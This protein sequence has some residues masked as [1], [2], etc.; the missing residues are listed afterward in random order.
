MQHPSEPPLP[1]PSGVTCFNC[2]AALPAGTTRCSNCGALLARPRVGGLSPGLKV[3]ASVLL[4]LA[5]LGLG[6]FGSC[7]AL[8]AVMGGELSADGTLAAAAAGALIAAAACV[9]AIFKI[10]KK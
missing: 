4:A 2:G 7:A 6:A 8:F 1:Q 10:N 5:A 9:W 3:V